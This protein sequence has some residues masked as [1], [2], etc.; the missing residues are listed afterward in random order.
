MESRI[1]SL[2]SVAVDVDAATSFWTILYFSNLFSSNSCWFFVFMSWSFLP[3]FFD[4]HLICQ[5]LGD[6]IQF[7]PRPGSTHLD[8]LEDFDM[9]AS[10]SKGPSISS[11][12]FKISQDK[13]N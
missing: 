2:V 13:K 7:S 10:T 5:Q 12:V 9:A 11:P 8:T 3:C 1:G 6:K 4:Y